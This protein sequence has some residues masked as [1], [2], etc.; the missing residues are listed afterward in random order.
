MP[1]H[2]GLELLDFFN[3][4]EVGFSIIFVTAYNEYAIHAFKMSAIYYL[5]KPVEADDLKDAV[6]LF[7]KNKLK[8]NYSVL[9]DNLTG[10]GSQKIGLTTLNSISFVETADILF[11][12]AEGA[13]TKVVLKTGKPVMVSKGLKNFETMLSQNQ[14]F[15]RCHKSY[16]VNVRHITDY[17]KVNGGSLMIDRNYEISVSPDKLESL[18]KLT[19]KFL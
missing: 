6:A 10:T 19:G 5:L 11:F 8:Q 4:D 13:Y 12:E 17:L 16:I 15:F 18:L 3:E 7:E 9:K 1:G 2:S 14:D